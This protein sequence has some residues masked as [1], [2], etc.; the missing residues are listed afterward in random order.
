[1]KIILL[2]GASALALGAC[3]SSPTALP[4]VEAQQATA[5]ATAPLIYTGYQNPFAEFQSR[6]PSE[7]RPWRAVNEEQSEAN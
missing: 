1:M 7:P 6:S 5:S 3:A 2:L 4:S